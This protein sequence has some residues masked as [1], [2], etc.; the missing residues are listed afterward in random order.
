[1]TYVPNGAGPLQAK[2]KMLAGSPPG[3]DRDGEGA[4]SAEQRR[5]APGFRLLA[6]G[7]SLPAPGSYFEM[8]PVLTI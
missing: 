8:S 2:N 6:P 5:L 4:G 3:R 7:A 1:M